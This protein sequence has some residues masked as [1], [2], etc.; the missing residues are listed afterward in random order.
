M[1]RG[2]MCFS[3]GERIRIDGRSYSVDGS[4]NFLNPQDDCNWTE[5]KLVEASNQGVKWLSV[6][7]VYQFESIKIF[8]GF[9]SR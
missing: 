9:I 5:Y 4:I 2:N 7:A 1:A 6:D 8:A 3:I